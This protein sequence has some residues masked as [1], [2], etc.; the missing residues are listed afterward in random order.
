MPDDITPDQPAAPM[1][2]L[3]RSDIADYLDRSNFDPQRA[4]QLAATETLTNLGVHPTAVAQAVGPMVAQNTPPPPINQNA[5]VNPTPAPVPA[6]PA[7]PLAPVARQP[8]NALPKPLNRPVAQK[9]PID[10]SDLGGK[11]VGAPKIPL[12]ASV[13]IDFSDLG[14]K[15]VAP[16]PA[17]V[18]DTAAA[19]PAAP[20]SKGALHQIGGFFQGVKENIGGAIKGVHGMFKDAETPE[21][22]AISNAAAANQQAGGPLV[23]RLALAGY[24]FLNGV[25]DTLNQSDEAAKA[26]AQ[27]KAQ[28]EGI[29]GQL[30]ADA[31]KEPFIGKFTKLSE[32]GEYGKAMGDLLTSVALMRTGAKGAGDIPEAVEGA[33]A[34]IPAAEKVAGTTL[35]ETTGQAAARAN[36]IGIGQDVKGMEDVAQ[37][38]PLSGALRKIGQDQQG[39]AREVLAT[40]LNK[41]TQYPGL[42]PT[43]TATAQPVSAVDQATADAQRIFNEN[44][45]KSNGA[46]APSSLTRSGGAISPTPKATTLSAGAETSS[47]PEDIEQNAANAADSARQAGSAKYE[48][49]AESAKGADISKAVDAAQSILTDENVAKVLPKQAKDAL[50]KV[51][52]SLAERES[53]AK[54]IYGKPFSDL[55]ASKQAEVSKAMTG[56]PTSNF[57]D[58]LKARSELSQAAN[59]VKDPADR[60][61]LHKALDTYDGA[62]NDTL[63]AHDAANG[64]NLTSDLGEAKTLWSQKYAFET[65]RDNLQGLMRDQ[66]SKG[67][68][69][70]NGASFQKIVN[71]LDP[72]GSTG[73][74]D[75]QRMFPDDPQSVADMHQ[76]ADFM[77]RNQASAGGM[78]SGMAKLRLLG[79]KESAAGLLANVSGFSWLM[80]KPGLARAALTAMKGGVATGKVTAAIGELNSAADQATPD[81]TDKPADTTDTTDSTPSTGQGFQRPEMQEHKLAGMKAAAASPNTPDHLKPHLQKLTSPQKGDKV[82]LANGQTATVEYSSPDDKLPILRVRTPDG[83]VFRYTRQKDIDQVKSAQ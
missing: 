49:I 41:A 24:R 81:A 61:Q 47:T 45:P 72:K 57:D 9:S 38:L 64:T 69:Q 76:L 1:P 25:N 77:G 4:R 31:E 67:P 2:D 12:A 13:G 36:P 59:G 16:A 34:A 68:R 17:P 22:E 6:P 78:A 70:I 15:P 52:Q 60:F 8:V 48:A 74:T 58:V 44:N 56:G 46:T 55:E 66:P 37:K 50:G 33:E 53:I 71:D 65:F 29:P 14:G 21:E 20:E 3:S 82:T 28:G 30:L 51:S 42:S 26:G 73:K 18:P 23:G 19:V 80:S 54:Q 79:L 10:F 75:L 35:P 43:E 27:A 83:K 63:K 7:S 62:V 11:R 5:P 40:K 32:Q 39:A